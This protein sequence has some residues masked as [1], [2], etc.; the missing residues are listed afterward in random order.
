MFRSTYASVTLSGAKK[1]NMQHKFRNIKLHRK[2]PTSQ[3]FPETLH[4]SLE[5][6]AMLGI[7]YFQS[8]LLPKA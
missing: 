6:I 4:M 3:H 1:Q 2:Q 7:D 5:R 8:F